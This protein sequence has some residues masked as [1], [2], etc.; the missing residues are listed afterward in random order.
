MQKNILTANQVKQ[1]I[2]HPTEN[3][4]YTKVYLNLQNWSP[5]LTRDLF[6]KLRICVF[7]LRLFRLIKDFEIYIFTTS[8]LLHAYATW[9]DRAYLIF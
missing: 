3:Q 5:I 7:A 6:R 1:R 9:F 2:L 8:F 4:K